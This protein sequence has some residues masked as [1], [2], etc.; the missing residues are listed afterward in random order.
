MKQLNIRKVAAF[1]II[2]A[3]ILP[4]PAVFA[5]D[6]FD[7]HPLVWV[8]R[9][10]AF[11]RLDRELELQDLVGLSRDELRL[12]RNTYFA[13][14]GYTFGSEDL[15]AHF[16]RFDW[17]K[18]V[19]KEAADRITAMEKRNIDTIRFLEQ[20][21]AAYDPDK[22]FTAIDRRNS[23]EL[24]ALADSGVPFGFYHRGTTPVL[25]LVDPRLEHTPDDDF[26]ITGDGTLDE[27]EV[28]ILRFLVDH[29][30]RL[31][32]QPVMG[33]G[34]SPFALLV[35]DY[36]NH[37][38]L[39]LIRWMLNQ[40]QFEDTSPDTLV[41]YCTQG[42][43]C[44]DDAGPYFIP[45]QYAVE[46]EYLDLVKVLGAFSTE[47]TRYLP[48]AMSTGNVELAR[49]LFD[50]GA[51]IGSRT[52]IEAAVESGSVDMVKLFVEKGIDP[53]KAR[54]R[55]YTPL[56][57]ASARGNLKI[58]RYLLA[59]GASPDGADV[60]HAVFH[61]HLDTANALISAGALLPVDEEK[62]EL[63]PWNMGEYYSPEY[64]TIIDAAVQSGADLGALG[65]RGSVSVEEVWATSA[66]P[67]E[68]EKYHYGP[69][70]AFDG[71]AATAWNEGT[72]G[73]GEGEE[74]KISFGIPVSADRI[75]FMAGYFDARWF[76]ANNRVKAFAVQL[77][78]GEETILRT[79]VQLRDEMVSQY[80]ELD[81]PIAFTEARFSVEEVYPG[82]RWNDLAIA[83]I[84]FHRGGTPIDVDLSGATVRL[85]FE[86][87]PVEVGS[88]ATAENAVAVAVERN[89]AFVSDS[90]AGLVVIDVSDPEHPVEVGSLGAP[91]G[92]PRGIAV[93]GD[94]VYVAGYFRELGGG[95]RVID[96]G[97]PAHPAAMGFYRMD[98]TIFSIAAM[99]D[100]VYV[101]G[102][103][104][105]FRVL[106]FNDPER[107]VEVGSAD[108]SGTTSGVV[109]V[110]DYAYVASQNGGLYLFDLRDPAQP[111]EI[112][113]TPGDAGPVAVAGEYVYMA[114]QGNGVRIV[115]VSDR[116][117]PFEV[118]IY[119]TP[120][121]AHAVAAE[122][123]YL[124]VADWDAGLR[125]VDVRDPSH[126]REIGFVDTPGYAGGVAIAGD[127]AYVADG[128]Y[129]LRIIRIGP[130]K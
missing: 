118:L 63:Y 27:I 8:I 112:S 26:A 115:D 111:V 89:L 58:V 11:S 122:G 70:Q 127:Y 19:G 129:G 9:D 2:A 69:D 21:F 22:V 114:L 45:M 76:G 7:D 60:F 1:I 126:P 34:W 44:G 5:A 16:S 56:T 52:T 54:I 109:L 85:G 23:P 121:T 49:L 123:S 93:S 61:G 30:G 62:F 120:G 29:G 74:L 101:T 64:A 32:G 86:P 107:P 75:E 10:G 103:G 3:A 59:N 39:D 113:R 17:Y 25:R 108:A 48:V 110:D 4:A 119:H 42:W 66:L 105:D 91:I 106:N 104:M 37:R 57:L 55:G 20:N 43:G 130:M 94:N 98:N 15:Q 80:I 6:A 28:K 71:D 95:I 124:Y 38:D 53:L 50:L 72:D 65:R 97:D 92:E 68:G 88:I 128:E 33:H 41:P 47:L 100:F 116:A 73:S 12:L 102:W 82:N 125:M 14:Y 18:P 90:K 81:R 78:L 51:Q 13:K 31:T 77:V 117:N 46:H 35:R 84:R 67:D 83:E 24:K 79:K 36:P 99:S 40:G 96:V 87:P